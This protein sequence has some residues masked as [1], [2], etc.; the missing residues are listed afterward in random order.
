MAHKE[1][2]LVCGENGH[3]CRTFLSYNPPSNN[4]VCSTLYNGRIHHHFGSSRKEALENAR[5]FVNDRYGTIIDERPD[6]PPGDVRVG[7]LH[8]VT[9][10]T[11]GKD[12]IILEDTWV[13]ALT[14]LNG[15]QVSGFM[16][17]QV[18]PH[19]S[20]KDKALLEDW[21]NSSNWDLVQVDARL[22]MNC[23]DDWWPEV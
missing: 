8:G 17:R 9:M 6:S 3:L 20:E 22:A 13:D 15:S 10:L 21:T 23:P 14:G 1:T 5:S 2:W 19:L 12:A 7:R 16:N 4:F 18:K 11:V